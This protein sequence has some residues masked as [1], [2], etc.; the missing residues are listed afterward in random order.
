MEEASSLLKRVLFV[1]E[2]AFHPSFDLE[3]GTCRLRYS[4]PTNRSIHRAL[5]HQM[6]NCGRKGC[7]KTAFSVA[8][9]LYSLDPLVDPM[10]A[11]LCIDYYG[12][13]GREYQIF[14]DLTSWEGTS[15]GKKGVKYRLTCRVNNTIVLFQLK[16]KHCAFFCYIYTV[17]QVFLLLHFL[18]SCIQED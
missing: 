3:S 2:T 13:L 1:L 15:R 7:M 11:L 10:G 18:I 4:N 17:A 9:L 14:L 12:I 8:R 16:T 5:F 6:K